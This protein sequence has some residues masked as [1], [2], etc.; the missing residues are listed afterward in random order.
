MNIKQKTRLVKRLLML[1]TGYIKLRDIAVI[2]RLPVKDVDKVI[3]EM[4]D[5]NYFGYLSSRPGSKGGYKYSRKKNRNYFNT[6]KWN[7]NWRSSMNIVPII[8]SRL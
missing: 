7:T 3:I 1:Q 5:K 2:T 8:S 6:I 4:R